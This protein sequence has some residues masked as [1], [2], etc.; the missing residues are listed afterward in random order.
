MQGWA[1]AAYMEALQQRYRNT[2][3]KWE[4]IL[5]FAYTVMLTGLSSPPG[6][7]DIGG[8][9]GRHAKV[10]ASTLNPSHLIIFEPLPAQS[11][12]LQQEFLLHANVKIVAC[13]LGNRRGSTKFVVNRKSPEESGLQPRTA[14]NNS[15]TSDLQEITVRV[16]TLDEFR[17]PFRVDFI[18]IDTEGGEIDILKGAAELL[19]RDQ[20]VVSVEYGPSGF[21]AYGYQ[22]ETLYD[23]ADSCG[24]DLYD[25]FG[26][27]FSSREEWAACVG[28]FYWDYLMI[29]RSRMAA[30]TKRIAVLKT[31]TE[32][33]CGGA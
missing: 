21:G 29:P 24:Y 28:R 20:P 3:I 32:S 1:A 8:H 14:Y 12:A 15:E 18:K 4:R 19:R 26:N 2:D 30:L 10:I 5:E 13:A 31:G 22:A 23:L 27:R 25:L 6:V 9:A 16:E 11:A 33:L 17:I 7:I